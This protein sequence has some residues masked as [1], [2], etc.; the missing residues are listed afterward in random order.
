MTWLDVPYLPQ[1]KSR[2]GKEE[3][4]YQQLYPK[5]YEQYLQ[6]YVAIYEGRPH[7]WH[8]KVSYDIGISASGV[9]DWRLLANGVVV[10]TGS[11]SAAG[12]FDIPGWG[13]TVNPGDTVTFTLE[14]RNTGAGTTRVMVRRFAGR[15][16]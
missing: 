16:S 5:L 11:P 14:A 10:F 9:T 7:V 4:A 13:S 2:A 1:N 6:Q 8:P 3:R 12:D 15:Q